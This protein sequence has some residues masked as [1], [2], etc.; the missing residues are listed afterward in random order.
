MA[1]LY[2]RGI[3]VQPA[4]TMAMWKTAARAVVLKSHVF[5]N[6][7]DYILQSRKSAYSVPTESIVISY[8]AME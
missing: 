8:G 3:I 7:K 1:N 4:N 5:A 6:I 2:A